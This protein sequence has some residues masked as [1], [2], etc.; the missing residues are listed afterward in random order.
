MSTAAPTLQST[1]SALSNRSFDQLEIAHLGADHH[2]RVRPTSDD[3]ARWPLLALYALRGPARVARQSGMTELLDAEFTVVRNVAPLEIVTGPGAELLVIRV[4]AATLGPH[5]SSMGSA[6]GRVWSTAEGTASIVGHLLKGVAAQSSDY[7]PANP[8]QL[9]QHIVGLMALLCID[10]R[11]APNAHGREQMLQLAKDHIE[12][13]LADLDLT[14]DSIASHENI[15]TRTLHRLFESEGLTVRGWIR[16]RRL[17][18]CRVELADT[19]SA[20]IPVSAIGSRWGLWDAAHFSRLFK[21]AY[22]LSPRA[23]R[24]AARS[25][26]CSSGCAQHATL[27]RATA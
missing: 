7:A 13:R 12:R 3:T 26:E 18:H 15:S 1:P 19:S 16:S 8:G 27:A 11:Q 5:A 21:A 10:G 6:D 17:E 24:V 23:Y 22:G 9:A 2:L 4:P 14:P 25:H 20:S